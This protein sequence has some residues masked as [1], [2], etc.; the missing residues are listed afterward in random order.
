MNG[1]A[2]TRPTSCGPRKMSRAVSHIL[3]SSHSGI[4]SSWAAIWKTL[5]AEV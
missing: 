2:I 5:S 3:Y 4:T 1:R